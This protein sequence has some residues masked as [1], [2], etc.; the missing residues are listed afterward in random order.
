[1]G[2][3]L[4]YV[5]WGTH[6]PLPGAPA[7]DR[8]TR[9]PPRFGSTKGGGG[10]GVPSPPSG[11]WGVSPPPT[12]PQTVTD[13]SGSHIGGGPRGEVIFPILELRRLRVAEAVCEAAAY[14]PTPPTS[15]GSCICST[16]CACCIR[17]NISTHPVCHIHFQHPT[18]LLQ[19]HSFYETISPYLEAP[20]SRSPNDVLWTFQHSQHTQDP[21]RPSLL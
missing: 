7:A 1:M 8:P 2:I 12:A 9:R 17:P 11:G 21:L 18:C 15:S 5:C 6:R 20:L 4:R 16:K 3:I 13:P 14:P 19:H 10:R